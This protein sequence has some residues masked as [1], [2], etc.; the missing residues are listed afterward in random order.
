MSMIQK[1]DQHLASYIYQKQTDPDSK[2]LLRVYQKHI[3][4]AIDRIV[5]MAHGQRE[6]VT[7]ENDWKVV[8]ELL[9][10]FARQWPNEFN[11]FK[12]AIP[13][14]RSSRRE[15]GYSE[16]K[17]IMYIGSIPPRFMK[18]VK[19]IFPTQQWDKKFINKLVKRFPL[20]KIGGA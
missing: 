6:S 8:E 2:I 19:A 1:P 4:D 3:V 9:R 5:E 7:S 10:F 11:N 15:K 16:S 17:E 14:I 13:D 20:F 18:L 12:N